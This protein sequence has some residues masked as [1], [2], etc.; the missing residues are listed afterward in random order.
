[1]SLVGAAQACHR[2]GGLTSGRWRSVARDL[3]GL[4]DELE[5]AYGN[6]AEAVAQQ[7]DEIG[8]PE[9]AL[10]RAGDA[11]AT[12]DMLR[13]DALEQLEEAPPA[14]RLLQGEVVYG[15]SFG[16]DPEL[17]DRG[18]TFLFCW[19]EPLAPTAWPW[20]ASWVVGDSTDDGEDEDELDLY[21]TGELEGDE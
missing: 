11:A 15:A 2:L 21:E 9:E 7:A 8:I 3:G 6:A 5:T 4:E 16:E 19:P 10:W 17:P 20:Q 12:L 18:T 1:E 14:A 13:D